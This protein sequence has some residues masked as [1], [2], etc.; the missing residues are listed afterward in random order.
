[1]TFDGFSRDFPHFLK[2]LQA[3]NNKTWFEA[4]RYD[5]EELILIP[6]RKL[7][8]ALSPIM[9]DIDPEIDV[10]PLVNKTISR[11]YRDTRFAKDKRMFRDHMWIKFK[12][13]INNWYDIP[14]WWFEI[15]PDKYTFGMGFYDASSVTMKN[16]RD[17][18]ETNPIK[19]KKATSFFPGEE[20][21]LLEGRLYKRPFKADLPDELKS[22]HQRKNAYIISKRKHDKL[23]FSDEL[24]PF[25]EMRFMELAKLYHLWMDIAIK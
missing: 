8:M 6:L 20:N 2:E 23:L 17:L 14:S 24:I 12:R 1:M 15:T 25:I 18:L 4:H 11:I 19:F 16:F 7:V 13:P 21:Y 22:W 5:Y 10:R 3:N 9:I